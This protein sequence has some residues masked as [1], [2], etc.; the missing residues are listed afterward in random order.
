MVQLLSR[1]SPL[2]F[3]LLNSP[4]VSPFLGISCAQGVFNGRDGPSHSRLPH[5]WR[6]MTAIIDIPGSLRYRSD[7]PKIA[8][9][10]PIPPIVAFEVGAG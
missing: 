9:K 7:Y 5:I 8:L 6:P 3:I 4:T 10:F 2:L 1:Q